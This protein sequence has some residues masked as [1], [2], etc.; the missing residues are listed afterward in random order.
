MDDDRP[1]TGAA[2]GSPRPATAGPPADVI[3]Q[4]AERADARAARDWAR[5]DALKVRVEAAGW[6]VVDRGRG[7]TLVPGAPPDVV[8]DGAILHGSWRS[9]PSMLEAPPTAVATVVA[10]AEDD[11]DGLDRLVA[12]VRAHGPAG[13]QVV[14]V[15]NAPGAAQAGRIPVPDGGS[16]AM[17]T[18]TVEV[19]RTSERLGR[20][21][22]INVG[23]RRS[24]GDVVILAGPGVEP[25]GDAITPLVDVMSDP[26]VA[27]AG[28]VGLAGTDLPRLTESYS[29]EPVAIDGRWL[30]FR[31]DDYA[32]LGPLDERF[33]DAAHLDAWW[34]LTLRAAETGRSGDAPQAGRAQDPEPRRAVRLDLPLERRAGSHGPADD[35]PERE[36]LARRNG[37]RLL[38][39]FR[40]RPELLGAGDAPPRARRRTRR[41]SRASRR[42]TKEPSRRSTSGMPPPSTRSP[43]R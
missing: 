16:E 11:P 3:A 22:A 21:A 29:G 36:R 23:L 8:V 34:S 10:V 12:G 18:A 31:R 27:V 35:A 38:D 28:A 32:R 20:A 13:T 5:A 37:Y 41:S 24:R 26:S 40:D 42:A 15:A 6:K 17:P 39:A 7:Y 9:V 30:A 33:V 19:V 4:A 14:V 1:R 25:I 2:P 43:G